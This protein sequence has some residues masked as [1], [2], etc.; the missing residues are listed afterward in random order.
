MKETRHIINRTG[1]RP[2]LP[3]CL[4]PKGGEVTPKEGETGKYLKLQALE[5]IAKV[6]GGDSTRG[7]LMTPAHSAMV[8][9]LKQNYATKRQQP[10]RLRRE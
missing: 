1:P 2:K 10:P 6:R 5:I 9:F 7:A 3:L 4:P 8:T